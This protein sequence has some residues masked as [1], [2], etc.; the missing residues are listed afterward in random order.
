M[1]T[2]EAGLDE[3]FPNGPQYLL[4]V[5]VKITLNTKFVHLIDFLE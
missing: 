4:R 2:V 5:D 3:G 1:L